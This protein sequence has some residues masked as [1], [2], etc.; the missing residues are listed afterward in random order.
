MTNNEEWQ[1]ISPYDDT[2]PLA[3]KKCR[4]CEQ[5]LPL[6]RFQRTPKGNLAGDC[7]AC[8]RA[9]YEAGLRNK[10]IV[11]EKATKDWII[12]EAQT[13]YA[14]S[15]LRINDKIKLLDTISRNLNADD[16]D[17]TNDAKVVRDLIASRKKLEGK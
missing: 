1:L 9:K 8:R 14:S 15:E 7:K 5:D 13:L 10:E 16:K 2:T 6:D 17:L 12:K 3:T 4:D 11:H